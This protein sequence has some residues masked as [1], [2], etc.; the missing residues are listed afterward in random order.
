MNLT[1]IK[2]IN[3]INDF[4]KKISRR[5]DGFYELFS[6]LK[7]EGYPVDVIAPQAAIYLTVKLDLIGAKKENGSTLNSVEDV[8]SYILNEA[9]IALVPFYAFGASRSLPWFRLS[10][11][12]TRSEDI[13]IINNQLK[14]ALDKLSYS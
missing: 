6:N 7:K 11:G 8:F 10:I 5:L 4:N 2:L 14:G 1:L 3:N 12:T 9:K 13:M